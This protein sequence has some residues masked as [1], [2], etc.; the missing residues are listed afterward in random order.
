MT[1]LRRKW[2]WKSYQ[3]LV[4]PPEA[5][6]GAGF[7]INMSDE[8]LY[9]YSLLMLDDRSWEAVSAQ[10]QVERA[11]ERSPEGRRADPLMQVWAE[12]LRKSQERT[13]RAEDQERK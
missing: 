3:S 7:E 4:R 5:L 1:R 9:E 13:M 2:N 6:T 11:T 12:A 8:E 10:W